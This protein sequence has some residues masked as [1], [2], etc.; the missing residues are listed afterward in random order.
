MSKSNLLIGDCVGLVANSARIIARWEDGAVQDA[1]R[2]WVTAPAAINIHNATGQKIFSQDISDM[3][4]DT[5]Y[6]IPRYQLIRALYEYASRIGVILH[7]GMEVVDFRED[8]THVEVTV[9]NNKQKHTVRADCLICSDGVH[10]RMRSQLFGQSV[11]SQSS[12]YAAFRALLDGQKLAGDPDACWIMEGTDERDRFEVFFLPNAQMAIQTCNSGRDVS[13]F[14]IHRDTRDLLDTWTSTADPEDMLDLLRPLPLMGR[15]WSVIRHT[16]Q[17]KFINYP[18]FDTDPLPGW[19]S[20]CGR[21]ILIG[22]AAHPL[23]PAAGQGASQ[24]IE[25]ANVIALVLQLAGKDQIPLALH[26]AEKIRYPRATAIQLISHRANERWKAQD[27]ESTGP[28]K[29]ANANLPLESWI[30]GHDS[31]AHALAEFPRV[32]YAIRTKTDYIPNNIPDSLRV[33]LGL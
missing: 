19:V 6:L 14:C 24:G 32:V 33:E 30:Y 4:K 31:Q 3:C 12:G 23:S 20:P 26:V 27:W 7:L 25:D 18:L 16:P 21:A 5:N 9:L 29:S 17:S 11:T 10:S 13:W 28:D 1:L 2:P 8:D 15:L 22:D